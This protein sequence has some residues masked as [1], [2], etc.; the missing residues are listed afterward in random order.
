[1][2]S[3]LEARQWKSDKQMKMN[4][5]WSNLS[6]VIII[7]FHYHSWHTFFFFFLLLFNTESIQGI[8]LMLW[9]PLDQNHF[10]RLLS[11]CFNVKFKFSFWLLG[12]ITMMLSYCSIDCSHFTP[13]CIP[14]GITWYIAHWSQSHFVQVWF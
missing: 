1:M 14:S 11:A 3:T 13:T 10:K 7:R 2:K 8:V 12:Q 4:F 5:Q 6:E 9:L